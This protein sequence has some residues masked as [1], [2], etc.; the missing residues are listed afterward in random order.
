[1][2][3]QSPFLLFQFAIKFLLDLSNISYNRW[4]SFLILTFK[5]FLFSIHFCNAS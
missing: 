3:E 1:M 5:S 2:L 4:L